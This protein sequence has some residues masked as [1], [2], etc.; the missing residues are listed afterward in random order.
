MTSACT[1]TATLSEVQAQ[2]I[3]DLRLQRLTALEQDKIVAEYKSD[4]EDHRS[5]RRAGQG[6]RG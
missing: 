3:L 1:R 5:H 4:G 2:Q 6:L